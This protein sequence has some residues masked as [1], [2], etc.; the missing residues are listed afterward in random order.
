MSMSDATA[1]LASLQ[2]WDR[3]MQQADSEATAGS[4]CES[5]HFAVSREHAVR[6]QVLHRWQ[7]GLE[8]A[9]A[10][11]CGCGRLRAAALRRLRCLCLRVPQRLHSAR[12]EAG[13]AEPRIVARQPARG[14]AAQ[15][16]GLYQGVCTSS[17]G[18]RRCM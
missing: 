15:I 8:T 1:V 7:S 10:C 2:V 6:H 14:K 5:E 13:R 3:L 18:R 4:G 17:M 9:E 12:I 16:E 11:T